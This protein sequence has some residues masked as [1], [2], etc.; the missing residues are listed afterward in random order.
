MDNR[1]CYSNLPEL[2]YCATE[3]VESLVF[4]LK[5]VSTQAWDQIHLAT[6]RKMRIHDRYAVPRRKRHCNTTS[7]FDYSI[8]LLID[9]VR[10]DRETVNTDLESMPVMTK[11]LLHWL[12]FGKDKNNSLMERYSFRLTKKFCFVSFKAWRTI[13]RSSS[14]FYVRI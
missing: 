13:E 3:Q 9:A 12:H 1:S 5:L 11:M 4:L 6:E 10:N 2:S 14:L 7:Q 8:G